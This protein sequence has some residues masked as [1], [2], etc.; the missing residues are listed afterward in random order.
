MSIAPCGVNSL[1]LSSYPNLTRI[2]YTALE[3]AESC[4][5]VCFMSDASK[6]YKLTTNGAMKS[7]ALR[8]CDIRHHECLLQML[9]KNIN[10]VHPDGCPHPL[11]S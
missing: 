10:E 9:I 7:G 2:S 5:H 11:K 4:S 1:A 8:G 3:E 6:V